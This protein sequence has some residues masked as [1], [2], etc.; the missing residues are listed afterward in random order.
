[1]DGDEGMERFPR[2]ISKRAA[3]CIK[4]CDQPAL[5]RT[6]VAVLFTCVTCVK[7]VP[8]HTISA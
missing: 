8:C 7:G 4:R 2:N 1:M 5:K 6:C 3:R